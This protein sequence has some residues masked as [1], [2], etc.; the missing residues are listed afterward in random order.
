MS[1]S[2]SLEGK[3][4]VVTGAG[5]GIGREI[6][7]RAAREGGRVVVNDLGVTPSGEGKDES[8]AAKVVAEI[9]SF[10]GEAVASTDT[11]AD[12]AA[13]A[14]IIATAVDNFGRIDCVINNAGILRDRMFYN[15]SDE[16][17]DAVIKVHLYGYFYVSRAAAPHFKEQK[18]GSYVHFTSPSGLIGNTGQANYAAA[19]MGI[20]GLST[21]IAF[22]MARF[23]V[24]SNCIAPN[25][26]SRMLA[27][28]PVRSKEEGEMMEKFKQNMRADQIAP[29]CTFLA[30]DLSKEVTGQIF[31]VRGNEIYLMSQPRVLR[32][33]HH[34]TGWTTESIAEIALPALKRSFY[35]LEKHTDMWNWDP[36]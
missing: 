4:I 8:I 9:N 26:W 25:A 12:S 34:G 15:M 23:N 6:A 14:R 20:V 13:A 36:I 18:S 29:M 16:E 28:I 35:P 11:I 24:R 19:K 2:R 31:A 33:V 17:W 7:L 3:V 27:G 30:S 5:Q 10:G 1:T 21:V 32:T 22:D